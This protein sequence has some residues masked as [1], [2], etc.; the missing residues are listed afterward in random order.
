MYNGARNSLSRDLVVYRLQNVITNNYIHGA[1]PSTLSVSKSILHPEQPCRPNCTQSNRLPQ[2]FSCVDIFPD[3]RV[4]SLTSSSSSEKDR[5][6]S[7]S[8]SLSHDNSLWRRNGAP[9][10]P[11]TEFVA[12]RTA[13]KLW[14]S[15]TALVVRLRLRTNRLP[16]IQSSLKDFVRRMITEILVSV[17]THCWRRQSTN[18]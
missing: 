1:S 9:M 5:P 6:E 7:S 3:L 17:L 10:F 8:R 12:K 2:H 4:D 16:R 15:D 11:R 13:E 14:P 18:R